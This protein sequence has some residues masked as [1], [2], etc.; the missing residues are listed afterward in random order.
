MAATIAEIYERHVR[1]LPADQQLQLLALIAQN[2]VAEAVPPVE[3]RQRNVMKYHGIAHASWDG[4][5]AQEFVNELRREW[6]EREERLRRELD[7]RE[8]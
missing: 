4:S 8:K 7:R 5:D 6:D 1:L 2:L 3:R